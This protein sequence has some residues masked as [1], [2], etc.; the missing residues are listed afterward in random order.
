MPL[1][2]SSKVMVS[3]ENS[4]YTCRSNDKN[5]NQ[6]QFVEDSGFD[7]TDEDFLGL[8]ANGDR[9]AAQILTKRLAPRVLSY[10]ARMLDDWVEAEDVAQEAMLK[11]WQI[12]PDWRK[13]EALV[14]TWLYRVV[15]NLV[16]DRL[17][18]RKHHSAAPF[19]DLPQQEANEPPVLDAMFENDRLAALKNALNA[20]PERQKQ[21]VILRHIEDLSNSEI[22]AIMKISVEAVESLIARGK[23]K[24]S[25]L[26]AGQAAQLGYE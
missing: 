6:Y 21:A 26:L 10:A 19:D 12:A 3:K 24:L 20:L 2:A 15:S 5:M 18:K 8:Y 16:I 22:A 11:L 4:T 23:R 25:K 9:R 14:S 1:A 7:G 17:R 13:G